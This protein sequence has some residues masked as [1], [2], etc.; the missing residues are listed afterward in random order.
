MLATIK[1]NNQPLVETEEI[2]DVP[3]Q[4]LLPTKPVP[5]KLTAADVLP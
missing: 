1:L 3:P 4:R 5:T 2:N